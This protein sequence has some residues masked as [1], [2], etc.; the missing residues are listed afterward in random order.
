VRSHW[1][2]RD[3]DTSYVSASG[4][5]CTDGGANKA[6]AQPSPR[7]VKT[8]AAGWL[9]RQLTRR[10]PSPSARAPR[11]KGSPSV[12]PRRL[13]SA[14]TGTALL[15]AS[16]PP[17]PSPSPCSAPLGSGPRSR[18]WGGLTTAPVDARA[19]RLSAALHAV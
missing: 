5:Q 15:G 13:N 17:S 4:V 16:G 12:F 14:I 8:S 2:F 18:S 19:S 6:R 3:S 1:R 10:L 11:S 7:V 9:I